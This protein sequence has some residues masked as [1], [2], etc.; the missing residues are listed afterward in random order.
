MPCHFKMLAVD[1]YEN[2]RPDI[3]HIGKALSGGVK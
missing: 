3:L 1:Y 2:A